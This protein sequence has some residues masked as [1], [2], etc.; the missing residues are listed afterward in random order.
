MQHQVSLDLILAWLL[1]GPKHFVCKMLQQFP[2]KDMG[3]WGGG[4]FRSRR[5]DN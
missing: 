4:G 5:A 3:G 2:G 1:G